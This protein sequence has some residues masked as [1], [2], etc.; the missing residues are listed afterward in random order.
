MEQLYD[1]PSLSICYDLN[2]H[3][4]YVEW[5]GTH[6]AT[7]AQTGG[8]LILQ[9]LAQR[10]CRK[11]L[12]DNSQVTSDWEG[13]ARWVGGSYY[14]LLADKGMRYVAWVYPPHW[15]A[16]KSMDTAMQF[17]TRPMVVLFDDVASAYTWL[18]RQI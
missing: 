12:N 9:L 5:K 15:S 10:P 6:D 4:L 3:W 7:S 16:R 11:M 1:T 14:S 17:V 2:N 8:E 18:S 13:G